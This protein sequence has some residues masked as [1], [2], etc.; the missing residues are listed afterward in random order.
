MNS[1]EYVVDV[2]YL[3]TFMAELGPSRLRL[4]AA[5][6]GFPCPPAE[7]FEYCDLGAGQGDTTATLA[8]A[9]PRARFMGIDINREHV[10]AARELARGG[11][12]ENATF[13]ELDFAD[14]GQEDLPRFDYIVAHGVASW[15]GPETRAALFSLVSDRLKP[16]GLFY[17]GYNALPGWAA[18]EPLRRILADRAAAV[19]GDSLERARQ[20]LQLASQL[21][22]AGAAYF[23]GNPSAREMLDV[24]QKTGLPYVVYE[25]LQPH[26]TPMYFADLARELAARELYYV[27]QMPLYLNYRDLALAPP[28]AQLL[29]GVEDRVTYET[30]LG[31]ANNQF[32]RRDVYIKGKVAA[33][34]SATQAWLD[35]TPFGA[36]SPGALPRTARLPHYTL[37]L[38]GPVF[39]ALLPTFEQGAFTVGGLLER[40]ELSPF[41]GQTLRDAILRLLIAGLVSPVLRPTRTPSASRGPLGIASQYNR[42]LLQRRLDPQLPIALASQ[43]AGTGVELS[44]LQAVAL[45]LLTEVEPDERPA[46]IR[47]LARRQPFRLKIGDRAIDGDEDLVLTLLTIAED[48][49]ARQVPKLLELGVLEQQPS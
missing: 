6:N 28:M 19:Q 15:I 31:Y 44:M 27:G 3:R 39:D 38:A 43:V 24:M 14:A 45:R 10:E 49:R 41:G 21:A 7:E 48:M 29:Q 22:G 30:L 4:V 40:P 34:P 5:L 17:V 33:A 18:V 47:A 46:W 11:G 8:A 32:F 25:Y 42:W 12:L 9:Y 37:Q 26:W 20:A 35:A 23:T 1:S 2:P 16:G 13:L 36:I